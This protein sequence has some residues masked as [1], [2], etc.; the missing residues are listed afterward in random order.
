MTLR[1]ESVLAEDQAG[2]RFEQ[3]PLPEQA[4]RRADDDEAAAFDEAGEQQL[5]RSEGQQ[6]APLRL[7]RLP[8][9]VGRSRLAAGTARAPGKHALAHLGERRQL[10]H[11]HPRFG[12]IAAAGLDAHLD[13]PQQTMQ[14]VLD[15]VDVLDPA[16]RHVPLVAEDRGRS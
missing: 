16:V 1:L 12:F 2:G 9:A 6:R 15:R 14:E 11:A 4:E 5:A 10:E 8:D 7:G 3:P 13:D